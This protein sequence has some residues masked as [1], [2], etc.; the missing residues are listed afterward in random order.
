MKLFIFFLLILLDYSTKKLIFNLIDL[1]TF[2]SVFPFMDITHIHNYGI[3]FG[4]FSEIL[5]TWIIIVVGSI[6]TIFIVFWM[7]RTSNLLEKWGLLLIIAGAVSNLGD[8]IINDYVLD[9]IYMH[10][11]EFYWPAFNFADIY[12]TIGVLIVIYANYMVFKKK[13][14]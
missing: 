1:H 10:Y 9:F 5:P 14:D 6:F 12:I 4:L 8:R 13:Y 3:T 11:K 2:I 7:F